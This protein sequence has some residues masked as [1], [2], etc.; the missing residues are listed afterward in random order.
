MSTLADIENALSVINYFRNTPDPKNLNQEIIKKSYS[1]F[2]QEK[3]LP[4]LITLLHCTTEYPAPMESINLRSMQTIGAAFNLP[5]GYSDHTEGIEISV[6]AAAM[7][8]S[9]IEK[10]FTLDKTANGPDH[11]ASIT[12]DELQLLVNSVR[13]VEAA[14]G[15]PLK[16]P[17]KIELDNAKVARKSIVALKDIS[18]GDTFS[19]ENL[20]V[21]RPGTGMS[22]MNYWD[23]IGRKATKDYS[24]S[25]FIDE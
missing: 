24:Q 20:S 11:S 1:I 9:I 25:D 8:A 7:G 10:H 19:K 17:S 6:A 14:M 23:L 3:E 12:P 15:S 21:I 5:Y 2:S 16:I 18:C 22:P 4:K 13:N